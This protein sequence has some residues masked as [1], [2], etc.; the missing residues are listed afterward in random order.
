MR[1][2]QASRIPNRVVTRMENQG[3]ARLSEGRPSGS[4]RLFCGD[5]I[6]IARQVQ[7]AN[8]SGGSLLHMGLRD[9]WGK[10]T[11]WRM[12]ILKQETKKDE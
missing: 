9:S 4:V 5:G 7:V 10:K 8:I 12:M 3:S 6:Q 1:G 2:C 11:P